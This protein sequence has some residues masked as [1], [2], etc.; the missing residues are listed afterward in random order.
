MAKPRDYKKEY[1]A[2]DGRP[3]DI[4]ERTAR[5]RARR[6]AMKKGLVKKGDGKHVD[7]RDF[8]PLNNS[9]SNLRI[10]SK[11]ANETRQP[12]RGGKKKK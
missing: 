10:I 3:K 5:N 4:K 9:P 12:S 8:N 2:T 7:H 1:E 6:E 11:K